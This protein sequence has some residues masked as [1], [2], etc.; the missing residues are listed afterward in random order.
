LI[1]DC[2]LSSMLMMDVSMVTM[3][4]MCKKVWILWLS[5]FYDL[6]YTWIQERLLKQWYTL[7]IWL[8]R[9]CWSCP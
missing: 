3:I 7:V 9:E 2:Q 4:L 6:V 1:G 8:P 5:S